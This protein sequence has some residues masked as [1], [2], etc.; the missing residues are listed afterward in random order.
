M[1]LAVDSASTSYQIGE[2]VGLAIVLVMA[3]YVVRRAMTRG[4][5][6]EVRPTRDGLI[7]VLAIVL[8]AAYLISASNGGIFDSSSLTPAAASASGWSTAEGRELR[9]GFIAG[10]SQGVASRQPTCECVFR[11][12]TRTAAYATPAGFMTLQGTLQEFE[13]TKQAQLPAEL[14]VAIRRCAPSATPG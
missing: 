6:R 12:L 11:N 7:V 1:S 4:F 14:T 3:V 10:C 9:A 2:F 13:H 8:A 5:G